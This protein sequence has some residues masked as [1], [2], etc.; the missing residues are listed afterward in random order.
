MDVK[1]VTRRSLALG[2]YAAGAAAAPLWPAGAQRRPP[3]GEVQAPARKPPPLLGVYVGNEPRDV[4]RFETWL[5]RE[6]DGVLG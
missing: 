1:S 2:F 3:S 6:V 5:G 4:L